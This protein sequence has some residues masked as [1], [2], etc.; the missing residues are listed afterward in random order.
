MKIKILDSKTTEVFFENTFYKTGIEIDVPFSIAIRM[1]KAINVELFT[2]KLTY[3][4]SLFKDRKKFSFTSDIDQISGWGNVSFNLLK[5]SLGYDISITGRLHNI[6]DR[7]ISIMAKKPLEEAGVMVWHEQP[8][9]TWD[10]SPFA[11]NIAIIP[12]ETTIIPASWIRKINQFDALLVPCQQNADAF[13]DSGVTVPISVI[14]WGLDTEKFYQIDRPERNTFTFGHM[15]ALSV[16]K[17]TDILI[18]AF[19]EAFPPL[20]YPD[21]RLICKTS[22]NHY[23]FMVKDKRIIVQLMPVSHEELMNTFF[24]ETDCFVFPT[25]GEGCG[26]TP[27]EAM[28]TGIPAI[29]TNWSGPVEYM[30]A[31]DGFLLNY[32]LVPAKA[33]TEQVYKEECGLWAEPDKEHLK[34]LMLYC[35]NHQD[36]VK[37]KGNLAAIRMRE[38]FTWEKT[39]K[40]FHECLNKYA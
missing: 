31:N 25:R 20:L 8:K 17:G 7:D 1:S 3:D 10:N 22:N 18:D 30:S 11:K 21:V 23:P 36:E 16:R 39:I 34:E 38:E 24:K 35:Y 14:H 26:M 2:N 33:F 19:R 4:P 13:K 5:N 6:T 40:E 12:F 9:H 29:V 32:S 37:E 27:M 28:S 15:G